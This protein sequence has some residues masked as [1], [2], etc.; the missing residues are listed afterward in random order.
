MRP[1]RW[2][3]GKGGGHGVAPGHLAS[4]EV[5]RDSSLRVDPGNPYGH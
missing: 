3:S 4:I 5:W 1:H 2:R